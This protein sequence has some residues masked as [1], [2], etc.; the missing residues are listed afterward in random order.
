MLVLPGRGE[1]FALIPL[2]R[3]SE[4]GRSRDTS[5]SSDYLFPTTEPV[6][7]ETINVDAFASKLMSKFVEICEEVRLFL[8][9][10]CF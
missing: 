8:A 3:P 4:H 7:G 1:L 2:F 10:Y 9:P 6:P 5:K